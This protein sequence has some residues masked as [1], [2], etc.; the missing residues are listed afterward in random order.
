M[1]DE[2][3]DAP[4]GAA[5]AEPGVITYQPGRDRVLQ[6][7]QGDDA[8]LEWAPMGTPV[9]V[10]LPR[11]RYGLVLTPTPLLD[12][13]GRLAGPVLAPD[14]KVSVLQAGDWTMEADG[15]HR[16]YRV[17][18]DALATEGWVEADT[19]AL[20]TA[21]AGGVAAGVVPRRI[22]V[23]GGASEYQLLA[24]RDA[25]GTWLID[26]STFPF[27]E[28][29]HPSGIV[30]LAVNDANGDGTPEVVIEAETIASLRTLGA[31]PLRWA[32]WLRPRAGRW[33]AIL[34]YTV[35]YATDLGYSSSGVVRSFDMSGAGM[36]DMVR[37][38]TEYVVTG[39]TGDFHTS[40][41]TFYP[42]NGTTYR[43]D[44]LQDLPQE[45]TV[46]VDSL[47]LYDAAAGS[48]S[49]A[50]SLTRGE[51]VFAFDR[52]DIPEPGSPRVWWYHVVTRQG[53]E[54]W[55]RGDGVSL[56]WVDPLKENKA[57]FLGR[58]SPP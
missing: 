52:G 31:A 57:V 38:D 2:P 8:G 17:R 18:W 39:S 9:A 41:V 27:P 43:K 4:T 22:L 55:V 21:E 1:A 15:F 20:V 46:A 47:A 44:A 32:A 10:L 3:L 49:A 51:S 40:A 11:T 42:W 29:F 25:A 54:G 13:D 50:P 28:G 19:L 23:A 53:T 48:L 12:R 58:E 36:Q 14:T 6:A 37:L 30:S 24:L 45:G 7:G 56:A 35:S 34:M 5:P 26:T 16:R 33:T